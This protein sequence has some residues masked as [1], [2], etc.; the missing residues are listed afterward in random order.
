MRPAAGSIQLVHGSRKSI[1][2]KEKRRD[3][4]KPKQIMESIAYR[5]INK[6][7]S[8][9][10]FR[11]VAA[12]GFFLTNSTIIIDPSRIIST[13]RA[14]DFRLSR[15]TP[16]DSPSSTPLSGGRLRTRR[17]CL[18]LGSYNLRDVRDSAVTTT[19]ARRPHHQHP[20]TI[21]NRQR[22]ISTSSRDYLQLGRLAVIDSVPIADNR[23]R[24]RLRR[25]QQHA[26][27]I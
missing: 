3:V 5:I 11:P 7:I 14:D 4:Y 12:H 25:E 15:A 9:S 18:R 27:P 13:S 2:K 22:V 26:F 6:T 8:A 1:Q 23:D 10:I 20:A 16:R 21:I 24:H 17:G 19:T